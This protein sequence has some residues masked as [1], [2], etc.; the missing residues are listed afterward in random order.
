M[1]HP[2]VDGI[3]KIRNP[4]A[5]R[6]VYI[7]PL[8]TPQAPRQQTPVRSSRLVSMVV[9]CL[10]MALGI[11]SVVLSSPHSD[12]EVLGE[13]SGIAGPMLPLISDAT[14]KQLAHT[15]LVLLQPPVT[16]L[17]SETIIRQRAEKLQT[18]L[19]GRRSAFAK[20]PA[21]VETIARQPHWKLILAVA[22]AESSLG[23]SC[24]DNNCSGIGVKRGHPL[25]REYKATK[26][27]VLDLNRLL[28]RRYKEWTLEDMC[29]VY[30]QPCNPNWLVATTQIL[31]ELKA[32]GID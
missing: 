30:V 24:P 28:E 4:H 29:G 16:E 22:N 2:T 20:D 31:D 19:A 12:A 13:S 21:V 10:I 18:Y 14:L 25:W 15:S 1:N 5:D 9:S 17:P 8:I 26:N 11:T 32:Q 7:T 3:A 23:R 27:W 6:L